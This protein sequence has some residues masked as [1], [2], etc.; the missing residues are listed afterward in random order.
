LIP[1]KA[2]AMDIKDFR[3][4]S[5]IGGMYKI[6][7]K[8]LANRLKSMLEKIVL[9]LRLHL[10]RGGKYWILLWWLMNVWITGFVLE[11]QALYVNWRRLMIM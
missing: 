5:L 3:P 7:S 2:G 9:I 10:S 4:I 11:L 6:I 8:V 1:K